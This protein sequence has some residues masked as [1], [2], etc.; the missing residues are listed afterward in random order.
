MFD[1][2]IET[3][4]NAVV[5]DMSVGKNHVKEALKAIGAQNAELTKRSM[6][7]QPY[8]LL[9]VRRYLRAGGAKIIANWPWTVEEQRTTYSTVI[10]TLQ[11]AATETKR[12]FEAANPGYTLGYT[13]ARSLERQAALWVD[14]DSVVAA[15]LKLAQDARIEV[16]NAV[17]LPSPTADSTKKFAAFLSGY[18]LSRKMEPTNAAPGLSDHGQMKAVDFYVTQHGKRV[19]EIKSKLINSQWIQTGLAAKLKAATAGT[20]LKGPLDAPY[21]PWHY[22]IPF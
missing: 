12:K 20:G 15:S 2:K 16:A 5:D 11:L 9:A 7:A 3:Y 22:S 19:A 14:N 1:P 10:S 17:Y 21:E 8:Q 13:G 6:I 4:M 18:E